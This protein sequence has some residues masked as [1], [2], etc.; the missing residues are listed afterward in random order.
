MSSSNIEIAEQI[1]T[2]I[3]DFIIASPLNVS[4][5]PDDIEREMYNEILSA[6][7]FYV[8][9]PTFRERVILSFKSCFSWFKHKVVSCANESNP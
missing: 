1:K 5:I 4:F 7:E 3:V 2:R 8:V 9:Q 6:V